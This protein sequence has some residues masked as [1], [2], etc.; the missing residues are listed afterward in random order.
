MIQCTVSAAAAALDNTPISAFVRGKTFLVSA[1][2]STSRESNG[3]SN[4]KFDLSGAKF[5]NFRWSLFPNTSVLAT[6]KKKE[7]GT[8]L[9]GSLLWPSLHFHSISQE[10][11]SNQIALSICQHTRVI[12]STTKTLHTNKSSTTSNS[13]FPRRKN[14]QT[15]ENIYHSLAPDEKNGSANGWRCL[16]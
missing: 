10:E 12:C 16:L 14:R 8:K 5:T 15:T 7:L 9:F 3:A 11:K 13:N 2:L 1:V 4:H 6:E